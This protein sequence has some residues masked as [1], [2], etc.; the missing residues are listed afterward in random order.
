[1]F[2]MQFITIFTIRTLF[3]KAEIFKEMCS[4]NAGNAILETHILKISWEG[5][6]PDPRS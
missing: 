5:M 1:M 3:W 6:L 4:Q 2:N